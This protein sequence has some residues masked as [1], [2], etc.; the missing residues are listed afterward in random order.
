MVTA[1]NC[2]CFCTVAD[3]SIAWQTGSVKPV[4]AFTPEHG[5]PSRKMPQQL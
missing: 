5:R 3:L 4:G 1:D 2:F